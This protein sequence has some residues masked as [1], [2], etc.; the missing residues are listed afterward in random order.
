MCIAMTPVRHRCKA[1]TVASRKFGSV[2]VTCTSMQVRITIRAVSGTV[3]QNIC[4]DSAAPGQHLMDLVLQHHDV[5]APGRWL[6]LHGNMHIDMS[7]PIA[8][9]G[10]ANGSALTL[11]F[12]SVSEEE[13]QAVV[14]KMQL[15]QPVED[16]DLVVWHTIRDLYL[17]GP[18]PST[19]LPRG[20]QSLTFGPYVNLSLDNM[21]LPSGLQHACWRAAKRD[22][23]A[24]QE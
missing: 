16:R 12:D 6:L 15:A 2:C 24:L 21:T 17:V 5:P 10:I 19:A 9:Q 22:S 18:L 13:Q 7:M 23:T 3:L 20:L 11:V 4:T 1:A 14:Q 8:E